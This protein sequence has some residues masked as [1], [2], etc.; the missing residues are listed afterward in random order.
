MLL[1]FDIFVF[2]YFLYSLK[3]NKFYY[4]LSFNTNIFKLNYA[5]F[6]ISK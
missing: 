6:L 1:V 4:F 3:K 5:I 2:K